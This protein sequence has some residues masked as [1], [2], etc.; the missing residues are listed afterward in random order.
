MILLK[1]D[2]FCP[3]IL[4]TVIIALILT[5]Q[6]VFHHELEEAKVRPYDQ[7]FRSSLQAWEQN[8]IQNILLGD[9][10]QGC[11]GGQEEII[12]FNISFLGNYSQ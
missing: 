6:L 2:L 5:V 9:P 10:Q 4:Y 12:N 3:L 8:A 11:S 7:R 1:K